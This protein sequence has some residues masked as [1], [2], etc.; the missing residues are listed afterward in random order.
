MLKFLLAGIRLEKS[1]NIFCFG[2]SGFNQTPTRNKGGVPKKFQE[3]PRN[4]GARNF[5]KI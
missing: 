5:R 1:L 2:I 4:K 3:K